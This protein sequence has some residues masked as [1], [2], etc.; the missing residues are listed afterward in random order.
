MS[1]RSICLLG[2]T[3]FVG[4][5][6]TARLV[7]HGHSVRIITRYREAHR[8]LLVLPTV[9]LVEADAHD[10]R[11]L[12]REFRDCDTVINL[13]GILNE[14]GRDG[15]GFRRI[16][17]ELVR[18]VLNAA[19]KTGVSR[20]VHMSALNANAAKGPS[21]YLRTKGEAEALIRQHGKILPYTIFQ[22]SVIFGAGDSFTN[23][24]AGLLKLAPLVFPLACPKARFAPVFIGDVVEAFATAVAENQTV[25]KTYQLCGPRTY[26]LKEI[27]V[28]IAEI[29]SRRRYVIGLSDGLSRLQA[30]LMDFVPGK[31]F[32]MDNYLSL[33]V[34]SVCSTNGL[35]ELGIDSHAFDAVVPRYLNNDSRETR[36]SRWRET[37]G[38]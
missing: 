5:H 21:N 34:D 27:V 33:S 38:R 12:Q 2:G 4:S 9:T 23:R 24:F 14:T 22:P 1:N 18:K 7:E 3:G 13:V 29:M 20:L 6:L 11:V 28:F 16:H 15:Q 26:T 30:R 19:E 35:A 25:G 37:A 32:S 8:D 10:P 36:F 31:P 17:V